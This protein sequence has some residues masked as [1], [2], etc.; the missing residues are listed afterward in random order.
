[1][2]SVDSVGRRFCSLDYKVNWVTSQRPCFPA[3]SVRK[4]GRKSCWKTS[5]G[6]NHVLILQLSATSL[7]GFLDI[8]NAATTAVEVSVALINKPEHYAKVATKRR[9]PCNKHVRVTAGFL[10]CLYVRIRCLT[11]SPCSFYSVK[12]LGILNS[13]VKGHMG[14]CLSR[15]LIQNTVLGL[16]NPLL[17]RGE[18][19]T[20]YL[21][22]AWSRDITYH[23]PPDV[24]CKSLRDNIGETE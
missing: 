5:S 20:T 7:V 10:P 8:D 3:R 15:V 9:M 4:P 21:R 24:D 18:D 19:Q 6:V 16:L 14:T 17:P 2:T 13:E 1:M 23:R 12:V 11:G 22:D